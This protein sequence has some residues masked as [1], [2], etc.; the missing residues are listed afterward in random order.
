MTGAQVDAIRSLYE[1][2]PDTLR[3]GFVRRYV[4]DADGLARE[5]IYEADDLGRVT[6]LHDSL[7]GVSRWEYNGFD[8]VTRTV[9]PAIGGT[10]PEATLLY[11][12]MRRVKQVTETVLDADGTPHPDGALVHGFRYD[13]NSRLV[14]TR[15]GT[16]AAPDQRRQQTLYHPWGQPRRMLD[17]NG[18]ASDLR[19]ESRNLLARVTFAVGTSVQAEQHLR[20]NRSGEL[21]SVVDALGHETRIE[22]DGFGRVSR[23]TDRDG[24]AWETGYDALDRAILR[25]LLGPAPGA[26]PGDPPII[27]SE[28]RQEFD[29]AGRLIR[30]TDKLYFVATV[31]GLAMVGMAM[32]S[33]FKRSDEA[34][35]AG[36]TDPAARS[37]LA[38]L[39][40]PF[41][42]TNIV[43]GATGNDAVTDRVLGSQ[44]RSERLGTGI[45][46]AGTMLLGPKVGK[47]GG[48][49][50][51][52]AD[53]M[54]LYSV[55]SISRPTYY[56]TRW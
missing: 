42:I 43:E 46:T 20:Y 44:E 31:G 6:V 4:E 30:R 5:T 22:R 29:A 3:S 10:A 26:A 50:G 38:A 45:G 21:S 56:I 17:E 48:R 40:E 37:A 23:V 13:A 53:P 24:N 18:V 28:C 16:A 14:E 11:D 33:F 41:G 35:K 49:L 36:Q 27:W 15:S 12:R 8:L 19:Y 55:P 47:L 51:A 54:S 52:P 7:G 2:F 25:R 39:G 32:N 9:Q 34:F 1:Y